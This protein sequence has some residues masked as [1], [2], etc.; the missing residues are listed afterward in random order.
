MEVFRNN[1]RECWHLFTLIHQD[2]HK[3]RLL[4]F[5]KFIGK[6][7]AE[8]NSQLYW[9]KLANSILSDPEYGVKRYSAYLDIGEEVSRLYR[10]LIFGTN[11][12]TEEWEK[13]RKHA[14]KA[15]IESAENAHIPGFDTPKKKEAL[16]HS[17][18]SADACV[19][20]A[21]GWMKSKTIAC[22][23]HA[24]AWHAA[25]M[26]KKKQR[27]YAYQESYLIYADCLE[28]ILLGIIAE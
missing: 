22:A 6:V 10:A 24:F 25:S 21:A 14:D 16:A 7:N 4:K 5:H 23:G 13:V 3:E 28:A 2:G 17:I 12:S 15:A 9:P 19:A 1:L 8:S 11:Q 26:T 27:D 18:A 20:A